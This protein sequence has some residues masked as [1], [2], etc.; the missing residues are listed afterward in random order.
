MAQ[1]QVEGMAEAGVCRFVQE[2]GTEILLQVSRT[3]NNPPHPAEGGGQAGLYHKM[4]L[5]RHFVHTDTGTE[6][7]EEGERQ[8]G[9]K[10]LEHTERHPQKI[11][12]R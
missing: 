4:H 12:G 5:T 10:E 3:D 9:T 6:M 7:N 2:N 11:E 1:D 8:E